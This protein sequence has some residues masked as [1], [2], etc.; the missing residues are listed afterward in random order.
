MIQIQ[1]TGL[2]KVQKFLAELPKQVENEVMNKSEEF[3]R[4]VQKFAKLRAP[5]Y[6]GFLAD[7]IT[8]TKKGK[9]ITLDTGQAYYAYYQEFGFTPHIIPADY[10]R[11]HM[12]YP[13]IPGTPVE[14]ISL[15]RLVRKNTPFLFPALKSGL[16]QL[17]MLLKSGLNN[18]IKN[19][20]R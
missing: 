12:L 11:Q 6:T 13:N 17:P 5:K 2:D 9:V 4:L 7:Q 20:R 10:F 1:I 19:S 8:V 15:F 16:N 18:A 3:M 14:N